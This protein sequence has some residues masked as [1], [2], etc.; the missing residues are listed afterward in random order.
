LRKKYQCFHLYRSGTRY[1]H[2]KHNSSKQK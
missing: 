2:K 1:V